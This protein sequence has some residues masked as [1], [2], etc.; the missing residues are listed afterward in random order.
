MLTKIKPQQQQQQQQQRKY[1]RNAPAMDEDSIEM[2]NKIDYDQLC[3]NKT[4]S[5]RDDPFVCNKFIRCNHGWA[6]KFKCAKNTAWDATNNECIWI[7]QVDCGDRTLI[8]DERLLGENDSDQSM[9]R[10]GTKPI[11]TTTIE[12]NF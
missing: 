3:D 12:R 11:I 4:A 9:K 5:L 1:R 8:T 10:N 6:Q 7:D 2:L